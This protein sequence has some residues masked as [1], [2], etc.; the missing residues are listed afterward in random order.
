MCLTQ[1]GNQYFLA[2]KTR[3]SPTALIPAADVEIRGVVTT[4]IKRFRIL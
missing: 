2:D 1:I 3:S 4:A